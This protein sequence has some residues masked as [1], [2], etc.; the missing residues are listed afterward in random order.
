MSTEE[1]K[2]IARRIFEDVF[3]K[4]NLAAVDELAAPN[5][6]FHSSTE[7]EPIHGREGL[8]QFVA[9]LR[10]GFPDV[11]FTIEDV[12]AE[13]DRVV[14]RWTSRQTHTGE[15]QGMP[16]TGRQARGQ[17]ID[18]FRMAGGQAE[19]VWLVLDALGVLQQLG[20]IPPLDKLPRPL[21]L[22]IGRLQRLS[23]R[24]FPTPLIGAAAIVSAILVRKAIRRRG[25]R[26]AR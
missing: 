13:G 9:R 14:I 17:G 19:E 24:P 16:P 21:I 23:A 25:R 20:V 18:I 3:N 22:L 26:G 11:H 5:I 10:A 2:A 4:G 7:P 12:V 6:I 8:R 15:Y 1:N